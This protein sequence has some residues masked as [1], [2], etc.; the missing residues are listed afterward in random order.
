MGSSNLYEDSTDG[1]NTDSDEISETG[2]PN[3]VEQFFPCGLRD[4]RFYIRAMTMTLGS[5]TRKYCQ[6][7]AFA[8]NRKI[9]HI[10][11]AQNKWGRSLRKGYFDT[12]TVDSKK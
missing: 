12:P 11:H 4:I 1:S 7:V 10:V 2:S 9:D 6:M 5:L 3:Q 8:K